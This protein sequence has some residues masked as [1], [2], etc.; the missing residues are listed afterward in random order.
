MTPALEQTVPQVRLEIPPQS[1]YVAIARLAITSLGRAAGVDEEKL[2]DLK[3]AVSESCANALFAL[4]ESGA[5]SPIE[6]AFS[7]GPDALEVV[8]SHAG[9]AVD[10]GGDE[11]D[12]H[13]FSTQRV[14]S[15][16]LLRSLVDELDVAPRSGGGVRARLLLRRRS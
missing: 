2:D 7:A 15:M 8:V 14:M 6:I 4:Q 10:T 1:A 5:D 12:S 13:G 9:P 11:A 3:I 16:A